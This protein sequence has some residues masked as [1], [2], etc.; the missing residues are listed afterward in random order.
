ML[1]LYSK[2]SE[3]LKY[4]INEEICINLKI[5]KEEFGD[6]EIFILNNK[7]GTRD[8]QTNLG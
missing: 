3:R 6:R 5:I 1:L 4:I 8:G 7:D 2:D